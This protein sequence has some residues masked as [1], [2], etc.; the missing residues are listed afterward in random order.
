MLRRL[1]ASARTRF[2]RRPARATLEDVLEFAVRHVPYYRQFRG[3]RSLLNFPLLTKDTIR[4]QMRGLVSGDLERRNWHYETSGGSTGE[5]VR[6]VQ[7]DE[8]LRRVQAATLETKRWAGYRPG[9]RLLKLWGNRHSQ[10]HAK[11][12][13]AALGRWLSNTIVLDTFCLDEQTMDQYVRIIRRFSPRLIVGFASSLHAISRHVLRR[14][15]RLSGIGAVTS[16]A[17]TLFPEMREAIEAAFG[18]KVFNRYGSSE[19]SIIAAEDGIHPGLRVAPTVHVETV[20]A[21]GRQCGQGEVGDIVVTSLA[22]FAMP[23]IRF[24]I[25]DVGAITTHGGTTYLE[26]LLGRTMELFRTREGKLVDGQYFVQCMY[27]RDWVQNFRFRQV[28]YG[29]IVIE[30]VAASEAPSCELL[31]VESRIRRVM[32]QNAE[33]EW[34]FVDDIRPLPSG[35]YLYTICE[36]P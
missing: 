16:T 12:F 30:A 14:G 33:I 36:V 7:D 19:V 27:F 2:G 35:K 1:I 5:P 26:K 31:D 34:R 28:A 22:N 32:G 21:D 3:Y 15:D 10:V 13:K 24:K 11:G 6:F 8:Y 20:G 9:D 17:G 23:L 4:K 29:R 25:G 18:C